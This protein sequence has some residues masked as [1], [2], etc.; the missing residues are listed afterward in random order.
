MS[1][2]NKQVGGDHYKR[3]AMQPMVFAVKYDL[4]AI[5][6]KILKYAS[7]H[8]F[9]NGVED[10]DKVSHTCEL[11]YELEFKELEFIGTRNYYPIDEYIKINKIDGLER[12]I[13]EELLLYR[14]HG[15]SHS[16]VLIKV[17]CNQIKEQQ[18][19]K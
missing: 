16:L 10:I 5:D 14:M 18:Y 11:A 17:C 1:A 6:T 4:N 8:K 9:K 19:E 13:L 3:M 7:R 12:Q 15:D 2:L